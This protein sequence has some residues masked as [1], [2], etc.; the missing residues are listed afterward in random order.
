M[1]HALPGDHHE[2]VAKGDARGA[3]DL[4]FA[5]VD[6]G[7]SVFRN[8]FGVHRIKTLENAMRADDD[9]HVR[10]MRSLRSWRNPSGLGSERNRAFIL[11][12]S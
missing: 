4:Y 1:G 9:A 5:R 7:F 8:A 11:I 2:I 10:A 6:Q 3:S 12:R